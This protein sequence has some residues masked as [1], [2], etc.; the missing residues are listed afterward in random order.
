MKTPEM[1]RIISHSTENGVCPLQ[2]IWW[3][4]VEPDN[5]QKGTHVLLLYTFLAGAG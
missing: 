4:N 2:K 5:H 3:V 1:L